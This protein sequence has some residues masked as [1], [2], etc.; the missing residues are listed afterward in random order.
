MLALMLCVVAV[1]GSNCATGSRESYRLLCS[2]AF[3]CD[4][5]VAHHV[6]HIS[7]WG[8][9]NRQKPKAHSQHRPQGYQ[10]PILEVKLFGTGTKSAWTLLKQGQR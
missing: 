5:T 2:Q 7:Q 6:A 1:A 4:N 3:S 9:Q 8:H 10:Q